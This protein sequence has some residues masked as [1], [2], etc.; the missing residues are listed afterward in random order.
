MVMQLE[1]WLDE[2]DGEPLWPVA[3]GQTLVDDYLAW[4][5]LGVGHRCET[6]LAWCPNRWTPVAVKLARPGQIDHLR[7]RAA[8]AREA[9]WLQRVAHPGFPQLL[10]DGQAA[11][12]PF[13]V[14]EYLDGE[15][16]GDT[17]EGQPLDSLNAIRLTLHLAAAVR[18][19]HRL[20]VAHLD[21]KSDNVVVHDGRP[22][23]IDLGSVR[24]FAYRAAPGPPMGSAGYAAPELEMGDPI[25]P[26]MDVYGLGV[27]L[28]E[29]LGGQQ[30][31]DHDT[32]ATRRPDPSERVDALPAEKRP[33]GRL[34]CELLRPDPCD[35]PASV[36]AVMVALAELLP[37]PDDALWPMWADPPLRAMAGPVRRRRGP[38]GGE[39][40]IGEL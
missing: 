35:R 12:V 40:L 19:L 25:D 16:L 14:T 37:G 31:F 34:A 38:T 7:A 22:V 39:R 5:R 2:V 11:N 3:P 29:A 1:P 32:H 17:V 26:R 28:L 15:V 10:A 20:G 13:I 36:E 33:L 24:P 30:V 21:L 23:L 9:D 6:W 4:E 27:L 8:L 18:R